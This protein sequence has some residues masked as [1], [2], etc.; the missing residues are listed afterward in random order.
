[1]KQYNNMFENVMMK[2][3]TLHANL[4]KNLI[5]TQT[6]TE[7]WEGGR[8]RGKKGSREGGREKIL[9]DNRE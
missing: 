8:K 2:L 7:G 3:T 4:K 6:M 9:V 5:C 1:M